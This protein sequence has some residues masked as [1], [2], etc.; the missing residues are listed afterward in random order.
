MASDFE[1]FQKIETMRMIS[2]FLVWSQVKRPMNSRIEDC[3]AG[4]MGDDPHPEIEDVHGSR[5]EYCAHMRMVVA[6]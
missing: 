4:G 2:F 1:I 6:F 3:C 5:I